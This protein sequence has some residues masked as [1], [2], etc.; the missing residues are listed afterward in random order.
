VVLGL[1]HGRAVIIFGWQLCG[2]QGRLR[3]I[4]SSGG[5]QVECLVSGRFQRFSTGLNR[6][7]I[8]LVMR[9]SR[10]TSGWRCLTTRRWLT[11]R[12]PTLHAPELW[13][14]PPPR[15]HDT[16]SAPTEPP[17]QNV[18]TPATNRRGSSRQADRAGPQQFAGPPSTARPCQVGSRR[19]GTCRESF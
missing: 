8:V 4:A 5:Q 11:R 10:W 7:E 12:W 6:C 19:G 3:P 14:Q 18:I 15:T 9:R 1:A 2:T 13:R 17:T 16:S